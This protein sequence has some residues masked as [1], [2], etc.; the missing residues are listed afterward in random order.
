MVS[1]AADRSGYPVVDLPPSAASSPEAA[2]KFLV[3][4]LVRSGR[5]RAGA[6]ERVCCQV[7]HRES[8]GSTG[9]G[10]G[11]AMPH[12]KSDAVGEVLGIVGRSAAPVAWP[13][14]VDQE[15]VRLVCLLVTP[16][17][18]PGPSLRALEA[19]V[20]LLRNI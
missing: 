3:A 13:D 16:T 18:E 20:R 7:L 17:S 6:A 9:V 4:E 12:S 19:A 10:R 14:A 1:D 8:L 2:V 5:L 11:V 15:P